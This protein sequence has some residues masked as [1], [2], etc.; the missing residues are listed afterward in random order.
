MSTQSKQDPRQDTR[1]DAA[2]G[3]NPGRSA[4]GHQH[5]ESDRR[6]TGSTADASPHR[7]TKASWKYAWAR[8]VHQFKHNRRQNTAATLS[9]YFMLAL[10][11]AIVAVL[12]IL[13]VFG[14][15]Q[16]TVTAVM[17]W[18]SQVSGEGS[19]QQLEQPLLDLAE[20]PGGGAAFGLGI[21]ASLWS[22]SKFVRA[23]GAAIN[24]VYGMAEGRSSWVR[25]L[26]TYLVTIVAITLV[27]AIL[28]C[29]LGSSTIVAPFGLDET[30]TTIWAWGRFPLAAILTLLLITLLYAGTSN[31][32][33]AKFVLSTIGALV[34]LFAWAVLTAGLYLYAVVL[35]GFD[36]T[37]GAFA[38]VLIFLFWLW[39]TNM[40]LLF[41]AEFDSEIERARQ[42]QAGVL[43]EDTIQLPPRSTKKIIDDAQVQ[44]RFQRK[45]RALRE[46]RGATDGDENSLPV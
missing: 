29:L 17:D 32:R 12:S 11:P 24:D 38:G 6:H 14:Q 44:A 4:S 31:V 22:A 2:G 39:L 42:L 8:T 16:Q 19:L 7:L 33:R 37:Y 9:F 34:A 23:F 26:Q 35:G 30:L 45:G 43:A 21:L 5:S 1:Q 36:S 15:G 18:L 13:N 3:P 10:L 28:L 27:V 46:S 40:A 41:G 25:F 20:S